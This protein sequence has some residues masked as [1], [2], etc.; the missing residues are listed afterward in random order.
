MRLTLGILALALGADLERRLA[1][2]ESLC[3]FHAGDY[4]LWLAG[5]AAL[6]LAS[7][8]RSRISVQRQSSNGGSAVRFSTSVEAKTLPASASRNRA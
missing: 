1:G 3:A 6:E 2:A 8:I 7:G 5:R 4:L